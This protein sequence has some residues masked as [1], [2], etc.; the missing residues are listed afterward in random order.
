MS[1]PFYLNCSFC[2]MLNTVAKWTDPY[3][4]GCNVNDEQLSYAYSTY[5][6]ATHGMDALKFCDI[7]GS[8]SFLCDCF[9]CCPTSGKQEA[10]LK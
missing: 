5:R 1:M 4:D 3:D 6:R 2:H 7:Q 10:V 9:I 8:S